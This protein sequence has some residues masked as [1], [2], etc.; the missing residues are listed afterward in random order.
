MRY[1]LLFCGDDE[2]AAAF[3]A[4]SPEVLRERYQ[5]VMAWMTEHR[6]KIGGNARLQPPEAA[7][8]VRFPLE[9]PPRV[10]DGP[11]MEGK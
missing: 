4:L 11:F 6:D 7:T 2:D 5:Q 9:G 3:A 10:I 1:V 8:T